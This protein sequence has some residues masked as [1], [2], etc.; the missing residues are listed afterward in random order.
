M[1]SNVIIAQSGGP[2]P[3]INASLQGVIEAC[4]SYPGRVGRILAGHHGIEG[5]LREELIDLSAE[6]AGEIALLKHTPAAGAIGTCRYKLKPEQCEDF[7]R[8]VAVMKAHDVGFFFY[9]GGND[10]MDTAQKVSD[11]AHE[12]GVELVVTGVPKTI[13]NDMGDPA[14]RLIDHTPGYGSCA[15]YWMCI[16]QNADEENRGMAPS[17][18]VLVLQAMGRKSGYIPA[19]ARLADPQRDMPLQ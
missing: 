8:I 15:R 14:F 10:S 2:S 16:T 9:I 4:Q 6:A 18:C 12:R 3:V 19:A 13:D 5:V 7:E 11:L 1:P 17:E